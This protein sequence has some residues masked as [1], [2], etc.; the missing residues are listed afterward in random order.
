ME[1]KQEICTE[2]KHCLS[3]MCGDEFEDC[4]IKNPNLKRTITTIVIKNTDLKNSQGAMTKSEL[5]K[6]I[7]QH[8]GNVM[9][10]THDEL[11]HLNKRDLELYL[12]DL[13]KDEAKRICLRN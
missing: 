11:M 5:V 12:A 13:Q 6:Y 9:L 2:C 8:Y 10:L 3:C 1:M 7:C 4:F